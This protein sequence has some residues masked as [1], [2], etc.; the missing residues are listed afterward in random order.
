MIIDWYTIIFQI[1]NF[2]VLV[3]LL[4]YFLYGPI[5][6]AMD[7]REQKIVEREEQ[8]V[9]QKKEAEKESQEYRKQREELEEQEE[10]IREKAREKAEKEK[11]EML[12]T[13][14]KEVD[15]TKHRWEE[16]FEREKETFVSELRR[17]IGQQACQ[18]ARRCLEDLADSR[19]EE[20]TWDL[21]LKKIK[22][23]PEEDHAELQEALAAD[24]YKITLQSAFKASEEN[25]DELKKNLQDV[26]P[27]SDGKIELTAKTDQSLICGLEIDAGGY[28]VAWNIDS[29]LEDV[30]EEILKDLD[31]K[32][33][34]EN[35]GEV[36]GGEETG[37]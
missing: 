21:F 19:L 2:L 5:I 11:N 14:R 9:K 1:L 35:S 18:V 34:V 22:A 27:E 24:N 13:A 10:E 12:K 15:E 17:R 20:L 32:A 4:R 36:P 29:Y 7:D 26:V 37:N 30:E 31:H 3:F 25:V 6:K 16:A 8:A 28:R 23:L 33:P